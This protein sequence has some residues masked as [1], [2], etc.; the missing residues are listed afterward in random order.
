MHAH[1]NIHTY[2]YICVRKFANVNSP[3]L[4]DC[5]ASSKSHTNIV[6]THYQVVG[7][8]FPKYLRKW[9]RATARGA[10]RICEKYTAHTYIHTYTSLRICGE[11]VEA[12]TMT[13]SKIILSYTRAHTNTHTRTRACACE[14][15]HMYK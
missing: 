9:L 14:S 15:I 13:F 5:L 3:D 1:I 4:H 6:I 2:I 12:S 7:K 11:L 8:N 10:K